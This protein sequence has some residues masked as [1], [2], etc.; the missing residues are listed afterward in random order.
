M[1]IGIRLSSTFIMYGHLVSE[2]VDGGLTEVFFRFKVYHKQ[3]EEEYAVGVNN[4][5]VCYTFTEN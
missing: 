5:N 2:N 1:P 4:L 3:E